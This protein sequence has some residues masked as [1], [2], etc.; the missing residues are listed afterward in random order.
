M[1]IS[2]IRKHRAL[3][4]N[5]KKFNTICR[6]PNS[7]FW[8]DIKLFLAKAHMFPLKYAPK[9]IKNWIFS[10]NGHL[11]RPL[12]IKSVKES[13][14]KYFSV[15]CPFRSLYS[16]SRTKKLHLY[17]VFYITFTK[18]RLSVINTFRLDQ[19]IP[20]LEEFYLQAKK[21]NGRVLTPA[22]II[23]GQHKYKWV[24]SLLLINVS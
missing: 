9:T 1:A 12:V 14:R 23:Q 8:Q 20:I 21:P 17:T 18:G 11:W 5:D 7:S 19:R 22:T 6:M 10:I 15:K 24:V 4:R 13:G 3:S 2:S 16:G